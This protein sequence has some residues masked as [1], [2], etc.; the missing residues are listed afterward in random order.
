MTSYRSITTNAALLHAANEC[1]NILLFDIQ[2]SKELIQIDINKLITDGV[3]TL[4]GEHTIQTGTQQITES[5]KSCIK[6]LGSL[7]NRSVSVTVLLFTVTSKLSFPYSRVQRVKGCYVP[8]I[9]KT[10]IAF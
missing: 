5:D 2:T 10:H 4:N 7:I 1:F 9:C 3:F 8:Y 6:H